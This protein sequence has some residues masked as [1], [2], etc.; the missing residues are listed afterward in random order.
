M[1]EDRLT[2]KT[3][4][5]AH[6]SVMTKGNDKLM[7]PME[8]RIR[9]ILRDINHSFFKE[10]Y[11]WCGNS[12]QS[13]RQIIEEDSIVNHFIR[14]KILRITVPQMISVFSK[15]NESKIPALPNAVD[16]YNDDDDGAKPTVKS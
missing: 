7:D 14:P 16:D 1:G 13:F 3:M 10:C 9:G 6:N 8:V 11:L 5:S 2:I 4:G 15:R 12:V